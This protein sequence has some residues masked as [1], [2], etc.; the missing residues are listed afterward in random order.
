MVYT[1]G[2]DIGLY[3][4]G[5]V[6]CDVS[7][8]YELKNVEFCELVDITNFN[9]LTPT[10]PL[11]HDK[12]I[13][14][15]M[16][17]F[18]KNYSEYFDK[19]DYII[20]ERQPPVG[21]VAIQELIMFKY[22]FKSILVSPNSMHAYYRI[23]DL[24]YEARKVRVIKMTQHLLSKFSSFSKLVRKHDISDALCITR[25]WLFKKNKEYCKLKN[26]EEWKL[27]NNAFI[28]NIDKFKYSPEAS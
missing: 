11:Y 14:D 10:C 3:H 2:I 25:Y 13:A 24:D 20:I 9:C 19:A 17:H 23:G 4:M 15:Y 22:R 12:C 26:I 18:F 21:L 6:G 27:K 28:K 5:L 16:T 1:L 7:D 8:S